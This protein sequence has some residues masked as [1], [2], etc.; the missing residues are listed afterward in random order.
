MTS[1]ASTGNLDSS[2]QVRFQAQLLNAVE[3]AVIAT[4]LDGV[5]TYWNRCAERLYGWT[6]EEALGH[7]ILELNI[8]SNGLPQAEEI[9]ACLRAG[10]VWSGDIILRHKDGHAFPVHVTDS[11]VLD[12][13]GRMVGIVGISM[14]ISDR[15]RTLAALAS[16][17]ERLRIAQHAGGIGTFEWNIRSGEVT[18]TE[19]FCRIWGIGPYASIR[20]GAF[21]EFVH[22]DDRHLIATSLGNALEDLVGYT[23]YRIVRPE[24]RQVR[25]LARRG[26]IVRDPA[27]RPLRMVGAVYDITDRKRMEEQ[28]QLLMQELTHR[29]KNTLAMVQAIATQTLRSAPSLDAAGTIFSERLAA[30]ARAMT[31]CCKRTGPAPASG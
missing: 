21:A 11:P 3:Q 1:L 17:E 8:P 12:D 4:D 15:V 26:E 22:P 29:V 19:E 27:G 30:L 18:V 5:V 6:A 2:R 16:S 23:E 25:W 24:D 7:N 14:E 31:H 28:R 13:S 20:A 10:K 9:M